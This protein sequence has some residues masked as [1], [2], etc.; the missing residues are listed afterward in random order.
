MIA[1]D[2]S[3]L[4]LVLVSLKLPKV[5]HV[6]FAYEIV[7]LCLQLTLP[8][9]YG[10]FHLAIAVCSTLAYHLLFSFSFILNVVLALVPGA[11]VTFVVQPLVFELG[12]EERSTP[13][14]YASLTFWQLYGLLSCHLVVAYTGYKFAEV[15]ILNLGNAKLLNNLQEGLIVLDKKTK[16][17][18]LTNRAAK[19]LQASRQLGIQFGQGD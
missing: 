17:V 5:V 10:D 16:N 15:Q 2:F 3:R 14:A 7:C 19:N 13:G 12:P 18:M 4:L 1:T 11:Y 8:Q 6:Y 9:S